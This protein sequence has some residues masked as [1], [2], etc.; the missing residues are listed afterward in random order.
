MSWKPIQEVKY[1]V[2]HCAATPPSMD[3][4]VEE[5]RL[6]HLRRGWFDIGYHYVI[7]RDGTIE[8][9]RPTDRP[10]AHA[11]GFNHLSLGI[12]LVGGVDEHNN[13]ENN[14]TDDQFDALAGL[15]KGL[16]VGEP[17]AE[18][19][20]HNQLPNVNKAC[21]SFDARAWWAETEEKAN[22]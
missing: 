10:G 5:I 11:R 2:I 15:V 21:P 8:D 22:G 17:D 9:G 13:P 6:W 19:L 14:F 12:C 4:G 18:V 7:R 16:K 1:I 3:V 20:G